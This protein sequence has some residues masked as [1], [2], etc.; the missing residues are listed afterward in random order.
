MA[1][2]AEVLQDKIVLRRAIAALRRK[3]VLAGGEILRKVD[4]EMA[5]RMCDNTRLGEEMMDTVEGAR[6]RGIEKRRVE[7]EEAMLGSGEHPKHEPCTGT[8]RSRR[9][10]NSV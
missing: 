6:K 3:D 8:S 1:M 5:K 10:P 4:F 7:F 2:A 9:Y